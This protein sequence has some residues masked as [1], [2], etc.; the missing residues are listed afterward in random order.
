[1][2]FRKSLVIVACIALLFALALPA[3]AETAEDWASE[4]LDVLETHEN[5]NVNIVYTD[6]SVIKSGIYTD[7]TVDVL[8][9]QVLFIIDVD[10][11]AG[12]VVY[13][14][15][16][17]SYIDGIRLNGQTV[18]SY[19]VPIDYTQ[20]VDFEIVAKVVYA[21]GFLGTL[22]QMS[23]GTYDWTKLLENPVGLLMAL[24]Y[25][26]AILS[27]VVAFFTLIFNK[28]KKVKTADEISAKV[29]DSADAAA[30]RIIEEK[31][32]PVVNVLQTT[33]QA[34][35]KAM[36]LTTSKSKEAPSAL[37]DV[38]QAVSNMDTAAAIEDAKRL[39]IE[40]RA[41]AEAELQHTKQVLNNIANTVQ[42]VSN[43]A[44]SERPEQEDT[45][46]F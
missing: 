25:I 4:V 10:L 34:V 42:E 31:I 12:Y 9:K 19:R 43:N 30:T 16:A 38:L 6:D 28:N 23:D 37:L 41:K 21:E 5:G 45:A 35:V 14:D 2:L 13:D 26:L 15:P 46:I 36:A 18:D 17:T 3:A 44:T 22:A 29:Q 32:L 11:P 7:G 1:M 39:V 24:Y 33:S 20:D 8:S 27:V 40:D